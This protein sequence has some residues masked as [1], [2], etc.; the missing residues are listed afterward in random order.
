MLAGSCDGVIVPTTTDREK[1][2]R[3]AT[4]VAKRRRMSRGRRGE[5]PAL[6]AVK[7]GSDQRYYHPPAISGTLTLKACP[8]TGIFAFWVRV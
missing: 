1:R 6:P 4:A 3:R 2:N 7:K 8:A 5:L